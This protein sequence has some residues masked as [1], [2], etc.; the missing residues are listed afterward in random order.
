[1]ITQD[2][3]LDMMIKGMAYRQPIID[4]LDQQTNKGINKY[5]HTIDKSGHL[6]NAAERLEYLA[7]ELTDALV[8]I[9]HIKVHGTQ[10]EKLFAKASRNRD[11]YVTE[12]AKVRDTLL[13]ILR[14]ASPK[15]EEEWSDL[16]V[17]DP[18]AVNSLALLIDE[19]HGKD[20]KKLIKLTAE[21]IEE[22]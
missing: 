13:A 18:M 15:D 16:T 3:E 1:M 4:R 5:G 10:I 14:R 19:L 2:E 6:K 8:Y 9:E 11:K 21:K 7:E 22:N 12:L 17:A 20:H